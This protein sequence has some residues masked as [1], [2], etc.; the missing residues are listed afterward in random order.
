MVGAGWAGL[1][2]AVR[3][4]EAGHTL[5]LF[6]MAPRPG[7]RARSVDS[8]AGL[9]D[10]GQHILIGAYARTLSLMRTVGADPDV[11]LLRR[12]LQMR[13]PDGSGLSLPAGPAMMAFARGVVTAHGW[14]WRDR[15]ALLATAGG[16]LA[17][18]FRCPPAA[19]VQQLCA[20]MPAPLRRDLIEPLCVAALN[21]PMAEA[22]ATVF[23]RVLKDALFSGAGSAD[24]LLPHR[25]LS[26]LLPEPAW[27]WLAGRGV[28]G[29]LGRRVQQI[30]ADG[31]AWRVDGERFDA[32]VLACS[33]KEAGRLA[34]PISPAWSADAAGMRYEPIVTAYLQDAALRLPTP[35][36]A[37]RADAQ[38]PAQFAFDLGALGMAPALFSFVVSGAR[39]W[40]ERGLEET[41]RAVLQ[42]A[43]QAFP[44]AFDAA[45]DR[46]LRHIAT[47]HRATFACTPA[48][49][50]PE[51]VIAPGLY[52]AGDYVRGPYPATLE[53][54]V[55]SGEHAAAAIGRA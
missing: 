26:A 47:E 23:L 34:A 4:T 15:L 19:T 50:R 7:G 39:P 10:N 45:D 42:Q 13:Y 36:T 31:T 52:A 24:L 3:A 9:L 8:R 44:G 46:V 6:D 32:V 17:R 51:P 14:R 48:L 37:L 43:R 53:G 2:T 21:T 18:G 20:H 5:T 54:A 35:M 33:A 40:V 30:A 27:D 22:S 12:P 55:M 16:W 38:A 28:Q 49:A 1:A 41:G 29:L 11:L 25:P